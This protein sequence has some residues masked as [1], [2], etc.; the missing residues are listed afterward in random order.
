M[1]CDL[2]QLHLDLAG[3]GL[4]LTLP[5]EEVL[6]ASMAGVRLHATNSKV[7]QTLEL[8]INNIQVPTHQHPH[9]LI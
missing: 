6:Y 8:Q 7:R 4:S 5:E 9:R 1:A 3:I 2:P